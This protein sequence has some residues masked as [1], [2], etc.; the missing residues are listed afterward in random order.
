MPWALL[1]QPVGLLDDRQAP[2]TQRFA[3]AR[4]FAALRRYAEPDGPGAFAFCLKWV[5]ITLELNKAWTASG[6]E[7]QEGWKNKNLKF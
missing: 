4:L 7:R 5:I 1:W 3:A 6:K 2:H